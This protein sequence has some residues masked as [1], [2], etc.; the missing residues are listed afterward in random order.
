VIP[1]TL[2][3][4]ICSLADRTRMDAT[5]SYQPIPTEKLDYLIA[6]TSCV[7][8]S[9]L[10]TQAKKAL[11]DGLLEQYG[12]DMVKGSD[13]SPVGLDP[14]FAEIL[15]AFV[16][17]LDQTLPPKDDNENENGEIAKGEK[18]KEIQSGESI[19]TFGSTINFLINRR[20][21]IVIFENVSTAPWQAMENFW[22]PR[23]G[24]YG[25]VLKVDSLDYYLP[26]T[27]TRGYMI[28]LDVEE[29]KDHGFDARQLVGQCINFFQKLA[30]P[31]SAPLT[32]FMISADDPR[33]R[34]A[35]LDMEDRQD[36]TRTDWIRCQT[37]H[38]LYRKAKGLSEDIR[39]FSKARILN[40]KVIGATPPSRSWIP[41]FRTQPTR[42]HDFLDLKV[43]EHLASTNLEERCDVRHKWLVFDISQNVDRNSFKGNKLGVAP[44]VTPS[45]QH[46]FMYSGRPITG[47]EGLIFQ[48]IP[49]D[50]LHIADETQAQ[51]QNMAGNAMSVPV[52]GAAIHSTQLAINSALS[53]IHAASMD[54]QP[55][56]EYFFTAENAH[57]ADDNNNMATPQNWAFAKPFKR[58]INWP[59]LLEM[60]DVT[61]KRCHCLLIGSEDPTI[62]QCID[63]GKYMCEKCRGNPPHNFEACVDQSPRQDPFAISTKLLS[64][65]PGA[66]I[67]EWPTMQIGHRIFQDLDEDPALCSPE[68]KSLGYGT[69]I[70]DL[71]HNN[72]W[73]YLHDVKVSTNFITIE[74]MTRHTFAR[75]VLKK[76]ERAWYI[77][78]RRHTESPSKFVGIL[79]YS[80]PI[81]KGVINESLESMTPEIHWTFWKPVEHHWQVALPRE[82]SHS[83]AIERSAIE[84]GHD[85]PAPDEE[86]NNH[87]LTMVSGVY[88]A[89]P[90]CGTA[91]DKLFIKLYNPG[92][93]RPVFFF[94]DVRPIRA[95]I[96]EV[97]LYIFSYDIE[98]YETQQFR[99][100]EVYALLLPGRQAM[101]LF[102]QGSWV[103]GPDPQV[104]VPR[105]ANKVLQYTGNLTQACSHS[106][107]PTETLLSFELELR[108]LPL[109]QGVLDSW[110]KGWYLIEKNTHL[111]SF[112][113]R[114]SFAAAA[115]QRGSWFTG[116][117]TAEFPFS[118]DLKVPFCGPCC[119]E[120]PVL[121]WTECEPWE[122]PDDVGSYESKVKQQPLPLIALV[123]IQDPTSH[124][125]A[126]DGYK[127]LA[128][129]LGV[130]FQILGSSAAT[131]IVYDGNRPAAFSKLIKKKIHTT[132]QVEVHMLSPPTLQFTKFY[133]IVPTTMD[134]TGL[135][136][137]FDARLMS[138]LCVIPSFQEKN[139]T[140]RLDQSRSVRWM[141]ARESDPAPF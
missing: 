114:I 40:G 61:S 105:E 34:A 128:V 140:L 59:E 108:N 110:N 131:H 141:Q 135:S 78:P 11:P 42:I 138:Q 93:A 23:A 8:F 101:K 51:L 81:A 45:C 74:Y 55:E 35:R 52:V 90:R 79:D 132:F 122:Y 75:L 95:P 96:E 22:L 2:T 73:Y 36:R 44:I 126:A 29:F 71:L 86:L 31:V 124:L 62:Y 54:D 118:D 53:R 130:S 97:D 3:I 5:G 91:E 18:D 25:K 123:Q 6:G 116:R 48:G 38:R 125:S 13:P 85:T 87:V 83:F 127:A 115:I 121:H 139:M 24:Y 20:P 17:G 99:G 12:E 103:S 137:K 77:Y 41:Y 47:I 63:C 84:Q 26:Q 67:M 120:P 111:Q 109:P 92:K 39:H 7:D 32:D 60:I 1:S 56:L 33:F 113:K 43:Q 72:T 82:L 37:R 64:M 80:T 68:G 70:R 30:H 9:N 27:R 106:V 112:F 94:R 19:I 129:K 65:L 69:A 66:F 21:R 28:G 102:V 58:A 88:G 76:D 107:L 100:D 133:K 15:G 49:V 46:I 98:L 4:D 89:K 10:N 117:A 14:K 57:L 16:D 134:T 119:L 104:F 50:Q 136:A